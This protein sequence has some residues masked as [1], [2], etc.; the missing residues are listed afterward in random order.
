MH[1][2]NE[3]TGF[4]LEIRL[5]LTLV[6]VALLILNVAS[7]YAIYRV[8][9][10]LEIKIREEITEAAIK[11]TNLYYRE[12]TVTVADSLL[13]DIRADYLLEKISLIHLNYE[14]AM[15]IQ[16]G[17]GP[18]SAF[19]DFDSTITNDELRQ[20]IAGDPVY[21]LN[22]GQGFFSLLFP[23]EFMGS[24]YV[25]ALSKKTGILVSA[26]NALRTL[27]YFSILVGLIVFFVIFRLSRNVI[28]PFNRLKAKVES[29]GHF[30]PGEGNDVGQLI[31]SYERIID[32]L[33][34]KEKELIELNRLVSRKADDLAVYNEYILRSIGSAIVTIDRNNRLSTAN[35]AASKLLHIP[36]EDVAGKDIRGVLSN[37]PDLL[38]RLT[39]ILDS[40]KNILDRQVRISR[41]DDSILILSLSVSPLQDSR[42]EDIGR[43]II[44][45]D[46]TEYIRLQEE[47]ELNRR[48]ATLGE[49]SGGLA[50][51]LRNSMGA[52]LGFT[53]L[54]A[55]RLAGDRAA[56][57]CTEQLLNEAVQAES[58]VARFLDY[59]RPLKLRDESLNPE[60]IIDEIRI[61]LKERYP[62]ISLCQDKLQTP[63]IINGDPLLIKQ[64]I[65]NVIDNACDAY[66]GKPGR[67]A[68]VPEISGRT[69]RIRVT[70][71]GKGI[72]P[73][74]EQRIF[75][76]FYSGRPS[77]TGLGLPLSQK[78]I[79][80]HGG[81]IDF[82]SRPGV[83]TT[84]II[85]LPFQG[86]SDIP[87]KY[88]RREFAR[89]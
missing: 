87:E 49:M 85:I 26:H 10:A 79:T 65:A 48:M 62:H 27:L 89:E 25:I 73:E 59:A 57:E 21:R 22:S 33:K 84:F 86:I 15:A 42:G 66:D 70:D 11:L 23:T 81:R 46:Q 30:K 71:C 78:I 54:L 16:A 58:M 88:H 17:N 47:L 5:G 74:E 43:V 83:Q 14:R 35:A 82:E 56:E 76:P 68:V 37:Y 31:R 61:S 63:C 3:K 24:K 20:L 6:I 67:V 4:T 13:A 8:G 12:G 41:A 52:I 55:K 1:R 80:L 29:S 9:K 60:R 69:L 19:G 32:D 2:S 64:A 77:G 18:D 75:T 51:Q 34:S 28:Y 44:L 40:G 53:R 39:E 36:G 72:S 7:Y 38:A 50:H 45:N